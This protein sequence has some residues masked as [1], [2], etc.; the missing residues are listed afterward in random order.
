MHLVK[1]KLRKGRRCVIPWRGSAHTVMSEL[2]ERGVATC[3]VD[4]VSLTETF[5]QGATLRL[6]A[7][8][9]CETVDKTLEV[10][11][12]VCFTFL[13]LHAMENFVKSGE[14]DDRDR[15]GEVVEGLDSELIRLIEALPEHTLLFAVCG[16]ND[17][18][19]VKRIG[20][21]TPVDHSS[22]K[23]AVMAARTGLVV[24]L[25]VN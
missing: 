20:Q 8:T 22:L 24:A 14:S 25:F 21:E 6:K 5:A 19:K 2:A 23:K 17:I 11:S 16:S 4:K 3:M 10:V 18:R 13:Q 12:N 9:D 7:K 15:L 1:L